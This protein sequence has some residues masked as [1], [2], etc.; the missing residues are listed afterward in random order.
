MKL[1]V[2]AL[3]AKFGTAK[4]HVLLV[5]GSGLGSLADSFLNAQAIDFADVPGFARAAVVGHK[6]RVVV[7]DLEGVS[8]IALQGRYHLYEGHSLESV[9]LPIR[10]IH[11]LGVD[12][13]IVTN[14]AGGVNRSLRAGSL[15][16]IDD[17]INLTGRNPLVGPVVEGETRFPD[18]TEAYDLKLR[19][20]ALAVAAEQ[21]VA[22]ARGVYGG[23]L[24]PTYETPAEVR[25]LEILGVDAVGMSTV[26]EVIVA[27]AR[28]MRVLGISLITNEAAGITGENLSHTDVVTVGNNAADAFGR[29]IRGVIGGIGAGHDY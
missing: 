9:T 29:L 21:G 1:T 12:T 2:D 5:L 6:G 26:P 14:A 15:M 18:M 19:S 4:P 3:R 8:C 24:G 7:G 11:Q 23:L 10:A 13:M 20:L 28:G 22:L 17:H 27:R 16:L 25:M